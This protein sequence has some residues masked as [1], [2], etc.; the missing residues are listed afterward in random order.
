MIRFSL[1][2]VVMK[3]VTDMFYILSSYDVGVKNKLQFAY[4]V[5]HIV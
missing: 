3:P 5:Y 2:V 4:K 1:L